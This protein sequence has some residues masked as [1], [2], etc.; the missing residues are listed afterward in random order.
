METILLIDDERS[1][2]DLLTV[3]F[4]KEGYAV[5]AAPTAAA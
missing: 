1:L 4:K 2:L 5:K 3:V